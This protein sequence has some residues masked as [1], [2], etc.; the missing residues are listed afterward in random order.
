M[1]GQVLQT[2]NGRALWSDICKNLNS[3][4]IDIEE[5]YIA[6]LKK[7]NI[8]KEI[9]AA[10]AKT[11]EISASYLYLSRKMIL[12]EDSLTNKIETY[13]N[14]HIKEDLSASVICNVFDISKSHLYRLSEQIFGMGIAEHIRNI[15]IHMAKRLL[16]DTDTPI[17]EIA[18]MVGISDYNYFTKVFKQETGMLPTIYR[19]ENSMR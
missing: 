17:Y 3:Y 16:G 2:D 12:K 9:I 18:D 8:L 13:I 5:L 15:R 1:F 14:S 19:K 11:M 7:K 6:Y 4:D 10:A